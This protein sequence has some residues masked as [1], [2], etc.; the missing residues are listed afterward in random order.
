MAALAAG[1][2]SRRKTIIF[3]APQRF[4]TG[5]ESY[6][7]LTRRIAICTGHREPAG[8]KLKFFAVL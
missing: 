2:A 6:K 5:A 3:A 4:E 8:V 7:W 1:R